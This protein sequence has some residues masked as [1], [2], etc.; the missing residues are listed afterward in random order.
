MKHKLDYKVRYQL[1]DLQLV[2]EATSSNAKD[3][4]ALREPLEL[5]LEEV[6]MTNTGTDPAGVRPQTSPLIARC[7]LNKQSF[8][9]SKFITKI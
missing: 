8:D 1:D 5:F 6:E 9:R 4:T 2:M 3:F 7:M